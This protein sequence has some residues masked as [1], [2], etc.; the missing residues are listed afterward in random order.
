VYNEANEG[1]NVLAIDDSG[2]LYVG[3]WQEQSLGNRQFLLLKYDNTGSLQWEQTLRPVDDKPAAEIT[4]ITVDADEAVSVIGFTTDGNN[5]DIVTAQFNPDGDPAWV[6]TWENMAGSIEFPTS[7]QQ[8]GD[9]IYVS[10][11]TNDTSGTK[12]VTI[13]YSFSTRPSDI[14]A[15]TTSKVYYKDNQLIIWFSPDLVNKSFADNKDMEFSNLFQLVPDSVRLA[16]SNKSGINFWESSQKVYKLMT[17]MTSADSISISRLGDTVK[18]KPFCS[19]YIVETPEGSDLETAADS[20]S[21]LTDYILYAGTA[22]IAFL[23]DIPND[24][25]FL[26]EQESLFANPPNPPNPP[27]PNANINVEPAWD[28]E[29]GEDYIRVGVLDHAI[30]WAHPDFGDGT[31][32]GSKIAG[33]WDWPANSPISSIN[34]PLNSHGTAVAGI[35]GALRNNNEGIAGIAGGDV[36]NNN[37]GV[38]LFSLGLGYEDT[39]P[40]TGQP[41]FYI[42]GAAAISAIIEGAAWNPNTGFGYGL[43]VEN[44]S[45]GGP[46][47]DKLQEE[48]LESCWH[49]QCVFVASRGNDGNNQLKY[50]AC[51]RDELVI[52]VGASGTDGEHFDGI[53]VGNGEAFRTQQQQWRSSFGGNIDV[54]APGVTDI[55]ASPHDPNVPIDWNGT[56][57]AGSCIVQGIDN[58][59]SCFNG[60][61]AAAPHVSGLAALMLS[62][63][64]PN[65]GF[66]NGLA[67]E[68]VERLIQENAVDISGGNQNYPVGYDQWNGWGRINATATL[69]DIEFPQFSVFHNNAPSNTSQTTAAN[70]QIFIAEN[71]NGI[72]AGYYF[73]D[74]VQVTATYLDVFSSSTQ[75]LDHW[76]RPSSSVGYSAA[77]PVTDDTWANY[78]FTINNNV[79]SVTTTTFCWFVKTNMSGQT[80]NKWIPEPP[81]QLRTNYS[82]HLF[83]PNATSVEEIDGTSE[84]AIYP[85]PAD[86]QIKAEAKLRA[87]ENIIIQ[88]HDIQ[89]RVILSRKLGTVES[90]N[91]SFSVK[92]LPPSIYFC[93]IKGEK[94]NMVKKFVK[95]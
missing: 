78:T 19:A 49:N 91:E 10:G 16:M 1:S 25:L 34:H 57:G 74:R 60:T 90:I 46:K 15:D 21:T 32:A 63:H 59:Y 71:I 54:I 53:H 62:Y 4:N 18:M 89:G 51:H 5:S 82:L 77:N 48:A 64:H 47:Y 38:Q 24:N 94:T 65:N 39:D 31:F 81:Q 55:V 50:P 43:D 75:I 76:E 67:P 87:P 45:W 29:H 70:Q 85:V 8:V 42:D 58:N 95:Q 52:N 27:F 17:R 83:D 40:I 44:C 6:R 88:I 13:K 93:T 36:Q 30:F 14:V 72:A 9:D 68:D 2:N 22:K 11:R 28:I 73:A 33:G 80:I 69:D 20:L 56:F 41:I 84:V 23:D 37:T 79:A 35:I 61:S 12:W 86:D 7:I 3:G 26:N 92:E 66:N